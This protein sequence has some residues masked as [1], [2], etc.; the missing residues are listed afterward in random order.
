MRMSAKKPNPKALV[1]ALS[2][3]VAGAACGFLVAK[4]GMSSSWVRGV[5]G[6]L[7]AWDLLVLPVLV[8]VVL[9]VH[10]GGHLLG[11]ILRGMRFLLLI[12]GPF[13][14]MRTAQ[15]IRFRWCFSLGTLGG[16]AG[17]L[18]DPARPLRTQLGWLVVGGPLA[19]LL[20]A[21][22]A[23][24]ALLGLDGRPAAYALI[25]ATLSAA[26]FV[27]TAAPFRSG[28]FMSD[29]MQLL[30]LRRDNGMVERR[31]R[32]MAIAGMSM[33]G[34]RPGDLDPVLLGQ[35]QALCGKETTY[36][37]GV[38]LYSYGHALDVGAPDEAGAW[39]DRIEAAFDAYPDGFR[40]S[41]AV[42]LALFEAMY[43][44][45]LQPA[46]T[47]LARTGGGVVD[48]SRRALAQ[49]A[50]AALLGQ[51]TETTASLDK[52]AA[53]LGRTMDPGF[54]KL[55]ADQVVALRQHVV[56]RTLDRHG[57]HA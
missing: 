40:Q 28:G 3:G 17:A 9:A 29:G 31:T 51:A 10:E 50:V 20:L 23:A 52:A 13:G 38:W 15:G 47:W 54:A 14:W 34:T 21:A 56:S 45:R 4:A 25:L 16:L 6:A 24:V 44:R 42:E 18:P 32:L 49:A 41:L 48:P 33:A 27:L 8:L 12:V 39:L 35:A 11:G 53:N 1:I 19:S 43:R 57:S 46:Q 30:Q 36:D 37:V 5:L 22:A 7:S 2:M 55:S 26:I